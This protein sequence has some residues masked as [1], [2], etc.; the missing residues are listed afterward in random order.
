MKKNQIIKHLENIIDLFDDIAT[1]K[2]SDK[3]LLVKEVLK[4]KKDVEIILQY[5]KGDSNNINN[6]NE[7][8]IIANAIEIIETL[9]ELTTN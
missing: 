8:E 4:N 7:I 2:I 6:L 1:S 9:V 3:N 5:L